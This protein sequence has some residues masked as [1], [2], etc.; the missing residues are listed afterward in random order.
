MKV[1]M[2]SHTCQSRT[3][4]QPRAVELAKLGVDLRIVVPRRWK[5]YGK[6]RSPELPNTKSSSNYDFN[7]G[8]DRSSATSSDPATPQFQITP[9][10]VKLAWCGPLQTYAHFYPGLGRVIRA[11]K[12]DVIDLW[13]EPWS[14]VSL[15]TCWLRD[16]VCPD[17]TIVSE[18]EQN[19]DKT[20]PP[21]F[22]IFRS[23]VLKRADFVVGRNLE[24]TQIVRRKG[25][26]G[27]T[28][29]V[30]NAVDAERFHPLSDEAKAATRA[31]LGW[32]SDAWVCGYIGRIVEEKGLSDLVEA[33][34]RCSARVRLVIVGN[35]AFEASL[36]AQ[37]AML[38]L[39]SRVELLP[40]RG[41]GQIA[42]LMG[43]LDALILPSRTT[44]RWKEQF[45]RVIIEAQACAVPVIGSSSGAIPDVVGK[46]GLIFPEGNA[47]ELAAR[48]DFLASHPEQARTM[49]RCGRA[50]VEEK[51]TWKRVAQAM[52]D[53]Y[54]E[55]GAGQAAGG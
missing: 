14:L 47:T 38:D 31:A 22:E 42:P 6:W 2:I 8:I 9:L 30:P 45:G 44:P 54:R 51:Y 18:T 16:R 33:L 48:L 39:G 25:F 55:L 35:G 10:S 11:W 50:I 40:A 36:R 3:E 20:L 5:E 1:L 23:Q 32:P 13:E 34:A 53:I 37:I 27:P 19:T 52:L 46:A 28:R 7:S 49:G 41:Q 17:A 24:S 26:D 12:P 43:A 21:P 4:G 29:V 15:Q